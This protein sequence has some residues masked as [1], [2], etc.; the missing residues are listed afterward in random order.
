MKKYHLIKEHFLPGLSCDFQFQIEKGRPLIICGENGIGKSTFLKLFYH[1]M[2]KQKTKVFIPQKASQ[3]F[4]D[5]KIEVLKEIIKNLPDINTF[6]FDQFWLSFNL[7]LKEE[8]FL[9]TLSGGERQMLQLNSLLAKEAEIYLLDEPT[10]GLDDKNKKMFLSMIEEISQSSYIFIVEHDTSW[11]PK[12]W[13][14][15][16]IIRDNSTVRFGQ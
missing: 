14:I 10:A 5:R 8:S 1:E 3:P 16:K 6:R 12:E 2:E 9:S 15:F 7:N 4:F 13:S 11:I